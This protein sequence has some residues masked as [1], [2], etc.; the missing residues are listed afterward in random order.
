MR[1]SGWGDLCLKRW[2][3]VVW[4]TTSHKG[5]VAGFGENELAHHLTEL[6]MLLEQFERLIGSKPAPEGKPSGGPDVT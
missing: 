1:C 6:E 4:G 3:L 2:P 5:K